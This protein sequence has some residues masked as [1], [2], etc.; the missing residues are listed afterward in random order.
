[1]K[2]RV[3]KSSKSKKSAASTS[4]LSKPS[5]KSKSSAGAPVGLW[6][7]T[8]QK[9][10]KKYPGK[11]TRDGDILNECKRIYSAARREAG[12]IPS[13]RG[14]TAKQSEKAKPAAKRANQAAK[15]SASKTS[16]RSRVQPKVAKTKSGKPISLWQK[17]VQHVLKKHP[18]KTA[19]DVSNEC[20]QVYVKFRREAGVM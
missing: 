2:S 7:K 14:K 9:V 13:S 10:L 8:V 1:M 4:S 12:L 5:P 16:K 3:T 20:K 19:K 6:S 17:A 15:V 18:G 11:T